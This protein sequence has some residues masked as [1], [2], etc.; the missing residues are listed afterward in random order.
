MQFT[1]TF[2]LIRLIFFGMLAS[3]VTVSAVPIIESRV[4]YT[5]K[6]LQPNA[7]TVWHKGEV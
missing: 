5:P 2:T 1:T 6:I 3:L 4:V 7:S